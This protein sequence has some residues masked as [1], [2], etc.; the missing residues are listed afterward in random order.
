MSERT[1]PKQRQALLK[2]TEVWLELAYATLSTQ[3]ITEPKQ[4]APTSEN[5]Q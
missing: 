1:T 5:L 3:Q 4:T 2:M